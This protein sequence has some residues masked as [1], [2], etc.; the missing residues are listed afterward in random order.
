[1]KGRNGKSLL[2]PCEFNLKSYGWRVFPLRHP[3]FGTAC[4]N[5][6]RIL[7]LLTILIVNWRPVRPPKWSR[8]LKWSPNRPRNYPHFSSR[9]PR[10]DPQLILGMEWYSVAELLQVCFSVYVLES[11]LTFHYS[12][13]CDFLAL[14]SSNR[15][16]VYF[17]IFKIILKLKKSVKTP[18]LKFNIQGMQF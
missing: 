4:L 18:F 11:H 2:I 15:I 17:C 8:T 10:N 13:T 6:L 5:T 3:I 9:R 7:V 12:S 14:L 1:M 16:Y